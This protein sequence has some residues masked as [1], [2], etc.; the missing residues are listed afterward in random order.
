MKAN[1][2]QAGKRSSSKADKSQSQKQSRASARPSAR[3]QEKTQSRKSAR[4]PR[5][6]KGGGSEYIFTSNG[7]ELFRLPLTEEQRSTLQM[8]LDTETSFE[9]CLPSPTARQDAADKARG[10]KKQQ[11]RGAKGQGSKAPAAVQEC[12]VPLSKAPVCAVCNVATATLHLSQLKAEKLLK[13]DACDECAEAF[14]LIPEGEPPAPPISALPAAPECS[15]LPASPPADYLEMVKARSAARTD[16]N[17]YLRM[18]LGLNVPGLESSVDS[19]RRLFEFMGRTPRFHDDQIREAVRPRLKSAWEVVEFEQ[20][21]CIADGLA[22]DGGTTKIPDDVTKPVELWA[23]ESNGLLAQVE[24]SLGE[25][26]A[27]TAF[28]LHWYAPVI[29]EAVLPRLEAT[30]AAALAEAL[31]IAEAFVWGMDPRKNTAPWTERDP[32][33]LQRQAWELNARLWQEWPK[34]EDFCVTLAGKKPEPS[35]LEQRMKADAAGVKP[36]SEP[37]VAA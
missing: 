7:K 1:S 5:R 10:T 2:S 24:M 26:M 23:R 37:K 30:D 8:L 33:A 21:L 18:G 35:Y 36:A 25:L 20:L 4:P 13:L 14:H 12:G 16:I 17:N 6:A 9:T 31:M 19:P 29:S 32:S 15:A 22:G 3:A 27:F 34:D 11:R 28:T